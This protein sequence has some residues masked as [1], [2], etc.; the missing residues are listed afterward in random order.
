[1]IE[2]WKQIPWMP[3]GYVASSFG[4]IRRPAIRREYIR[5]GRPH[6]DHLMPKVLAGEK[7]SAKGYLR[8][9]LGNKTQQVHRVIAA[10]FIENPLKKP[11][12]NHKNGI[13]TD[14]RVENLEWVTNQENR[15]HAVKHGLHAMGDD[16]SRKL[17]SGDIDRIRD[18]AACG[19]LQNRIGQHFG[20]QQQAI[21]KVIT[22]IAWRHVRPATQS[23][24]RIIKP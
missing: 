7:T 1:M 11:Q 21:S 6:A 24:I 14:N 23:G 9:N 18:L 19:E 3:E 20:V 4:R 22:G 8:V 10:V 13:K 15:D 12:I 2:E 16:C 17:C 5:N